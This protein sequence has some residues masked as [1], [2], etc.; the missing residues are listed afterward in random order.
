MILHGPGKS[1]S[2]QNGVEKTVSGVGLT[3]I[4]DLQHN[5]LFY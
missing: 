1:S 4:Q 2:K 3:V 5:I